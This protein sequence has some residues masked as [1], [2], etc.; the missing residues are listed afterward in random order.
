MKNKKYVLLLIVLSI[1]IIGMLCGTAT[2]SHTFTKGKYKVTVSDSTYNK[3]KKGKTTVV[4][5][6][7]TKKK[8]K[9]V[10]KK[11]KSYQTWKNK[12][13]K[14]YKIKEWAPPSKWGDNIKYVKTVFK[15][16]K[17]GDIRYD[18]YKV[19]TT[20]KKPVYM[21]IYPQWSGDLEHPK[22]TGK[23]AVQ[24]SNTKIMAF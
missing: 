3:L 7:G 17:K 5:K 14:V 16:S 12:K 18:Y 19:K 23:I 22:V 13:G 9:W 11:T 1:F 6:V 8:T 2:A 21:Q 4:K 24:L 20:V 10:T 15:H